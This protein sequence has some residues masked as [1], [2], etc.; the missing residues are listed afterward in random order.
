MYE[1]KVLTL[2]V[3]ESEK[4]YNQL[5]KEGWRVVSVISNLAKGMGV[6]ATLER[7]IKE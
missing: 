4:T 7:T 6:I 2:S 3:K 1:Y 5:A